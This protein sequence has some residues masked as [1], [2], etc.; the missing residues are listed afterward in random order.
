[1]VL[2][3]LFKFLGRISLLKVTVNDIECIYEYVLYEGD[4][5][6][7]NFVMVDHDI[8]WSSDHP[9]IDFIVSFF[10]I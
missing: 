1:M 3:V 6:S 2:L 5:V 10:F 9:S 8:F 7:G 4:N